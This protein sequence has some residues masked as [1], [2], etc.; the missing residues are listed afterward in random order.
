MPA[1]LQLDEL[2]D[3]LVLLLLL[4]RRVRDRVRD[5][6]V[7]LAGDDQ[8]RAAV[9]PL[10]V[11]FCLG[12]GVQ[13]RVRRL[14]DRLAR[15]GDRVRLV[16]LL[17]LFF[18]DGVGEPVAELLVGER[19]CTVAVARVLE[20]RRR[21]PQRADR[22]RQ[23]AAERCGVDR[24]RD[25]GEPAPRD[26]LREQSAERVADHGRLLV[27]PGED[28]GDVVRDVADPLACEDLRARL[29]DAA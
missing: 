29:E 1:A 17:R 23:H 13:V 24:N 18:A 28:V 27:E 4:V 11:D 22:E 19:H 9:G 14:E 10:R 26:D 25:G 3:V 2:G 8:Q 7:E 20:H 12:P 5:G 16:Q 15:T 6:V 21:R